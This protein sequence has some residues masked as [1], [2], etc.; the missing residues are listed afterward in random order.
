MSFKL[1]VDLKNRF[2]VFQRPFL[3]TKTFFKPIRRFPTVGDTYWSVS[4]LARAKGLN[5]R[6]PPPLPKD[7]D[8]EE[9]WRAEVV[10]ERDDDEEE[11]DKGEQ[12]HT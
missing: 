2:V 10:N 11:Q 9:G 1:L 5:P 4:A 6:P 12:V 8:R 7:T 3:S